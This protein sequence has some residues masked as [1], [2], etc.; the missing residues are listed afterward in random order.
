MTSDSETASRPV[1]TSTRGRELVD[2]SAYD[3]TRHDPGASTMKRMLWYWINAVIFGSWLCP[4]YAVKRQMIRAFGGEIG[5]G[6]VIKPRVNIKYP[7][8]LSIGDYA[9]VGEGAWIDNMESVRIG[10]H[11]CISQGVYLCTGNHDWSEPKFSLVA[12]P[13]VVA[14]QAW[15]GAFSI[16]GPGVVIGE[17]SVTTAG[18]VVTADTQPWMIY[19]GNPAEAV[20][21]RKVAGTRASN[22]P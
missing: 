11:C 8:K 1:G 6:V 2:L 13:I 19:A 3:P 14:S 18:S 16:I 21:P 7:W 9:W 17:G 15:L 10:P 22:D 20:R 12:R 5:K 4:L